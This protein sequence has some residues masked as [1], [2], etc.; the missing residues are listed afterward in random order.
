ML[1]MSPDRTPSRP[2]SSGNGITKTIGKTTTWCPTSAPSPISS[3]SPRGA[4]QPVPVQLTE[5][6]A[7]LNFTSRSWVNAFYVQDQWTIKRLTLNL[8]MRID[9]ERGYAPAQTE[10]ATAFTPAHDFAAVNNIPDW[11]DIEPRIGADFDVF[12]N[13]KVA[14]KGALGRM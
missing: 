14:I 11:N 1:S 6:A 12:G 8:G 9:V 4:P 2:A 7:P 3:I 13:G 5:Y 10:A